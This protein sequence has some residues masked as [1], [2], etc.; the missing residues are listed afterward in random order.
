[1]LLSDLPT[2]PKFS[3]GWNGSP[4]ALDLFAARRERISDVYLA[5]PGA[6]TGR[7]SGLEKAPGHA[8]RTE[9]FVRGLVRHGLRPN[10]LFNGMCQG[11]LTGSRRWTEFLCSTLERFS[12]LGVTDVT[13]S[14]AVDMAVV[15][16][17]FPGLTVHSSVN[18]F[19]DSVA[20]CAQI[21]DI[22]D[23]INL[24]RS[25]NYDFERL[26]ELR[27]Y[28]RCKILKI[29]VNEGCLYQCVHRIHHFNALAHGTNTEEPFCKR[30]FLQNP[31]IVLHTPV[32]RPEDIFHYTGVV[33]VIKLATRHVGSVEH[34]RLT[35]DAYIEEE[36]D[37]NLLDLISSDGL[38]SA[39]ETA[40]CFHIDNKAIPLDYFVRRAE[41]K[42]LWIA[43]ILR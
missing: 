14:S 27:E 26:G 5:A 33:D 4:E 37:G 31:H 43:D 19:I 1:M 25:I 9:A 30:H 22:A 13:C 15:K 16:T 39:Q 11:E 32:I 20:K 35:L 36:Y 18:M 2:T 8:A 3:V 6:P 28:A 38:A 34:L 24:D 41:A 23:V 40:G 7:N 42:G 12:A 21:I 17:R 29:L 10:L